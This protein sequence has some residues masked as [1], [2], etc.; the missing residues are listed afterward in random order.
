M[1]PAMRGIAMVTA[2]A[3]AFIVVGGPG[4]R[5]AAQPAEP[6]GDPSDAA[7]LFL[8]G[9]ELLKLG[10]RAEACELFDRSYQ[11]D[12]APGTGV[13]LAVC[14][15]DQG[16]L[17]QAWELFDR[18]ARA[19]PNVQSRVQL[20][21]QRADALRLR[22]ATVVVKLGAVRSS[23]L[24]VRVGDRELDAVPGQPEVRAIVEPGTLEV[25]A[26]QPGQPEIRIAVAA[27]AGADV[28][29]DVA[30]AIA[31]RAPVRQ[32]VRRSGPG[33]YV[34]GGIGAAGVA[35]L[36]VS[37]GF[38]LAARRAN[39]DAFDHGCEHSSRGVVCTGPP[40]GINQG[41]RLVHLAGARADL[42]TGFAIGGA[43]LVGAAATVFVVSRDHL[44]VAP[45]ATAHAVGVGLAGRF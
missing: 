41:G 18:V 16:Q 3:L 40:G 13:N 4:G 9:R 26:T 45:L 28:V 12:P 8:R 24:A 29:A 23:G 43:V 31:A 6:A 7:Q 1:L 20:A 19:T 2:I 11:L 15:E 5:A 27:V 39:H 36:G 21:R 44:Q 30:Q 35:G 34:A 14:L 17:R 33:I 32:P 37:L 10:Q 42:A 38:A 25:V 22:L